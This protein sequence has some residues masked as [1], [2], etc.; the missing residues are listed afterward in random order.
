MK[1]TSL[2]LNARCK[3]AAAFLFAAILS[4]GFTA[5]S[6]NSDNPINPSGPEIT[7]K[8][9]A[10]YAKT[11]TVPGFEEGDNPV[12]FVKMVQ[13]YE[14]EAD[15]TGRWTVF[16]VDKDNV[17]VWQYGSLVGLDYAAGYFNYS[18]NSDGTVNI[19]LLNELEENPHHSWTLHLTG[20]RLTGNDEG[21]TYALAHATA[22]QEAWVKD[23][24]A[25]YHGGLSEAFNINTQRIKW[26][27]QGSIVEPITADNW[28]DHEDI[29]IYIQN[30]GDK[31]I[32][33]ADNG[34]EMHGFEH[35]KLPWATTANESPNL[36]ERIW[37]EVWNDGV[38][39]GNPWS[40]IMMQIG[41]NTV[42][43]GN[44]LAFYNELTG[45]MRF[46]FYVHESITSNG[47]THWWGV[48]M[49]DRLASRSVFRYGAPLNCDIT[50]NAAKDALN[51]PALMGQ[52]ISP[53]VSNNFN[54]S[55]L[56]LQSGWWAFDVDLS[57]YR[58]GLDKEA[59]VATIS[60][61]DNAFT[62]NL[63]AKDNMQVEL[64]SLFEGTMDGNLNLEATYAN[65]ENG[66][67]SE[68]GDFIDK[69]E[70]V[71]G[72][73]MDFGSQ[74]KD[75]YESTMKG[76]PIGQLK[77]IY[78][79]GKKGAT[80]AGLIEEK[81]DEPDKLTG[82]KGTINM[83]MKGKMDTKGYLS[84]NRGVNGFAG[85]VLKRNNFLYDNC[86]TFGEGIWNLEEAPV[87][88][89]TN[90]YYYWT[91][92]WGNV[93]DGKMSYEKGDVAEVR[94]TKTKSPFGGQY[95]KAYYGA[96]RIVNTPSKEPYAGYICYFDP[97]SIKL[98]LNPNVFTAEEIAN[99]K[100]YAV[101]GV[102]SSNS[103]GSTEGY[104][105]AQNLSSSE[106][107]FSSNYAYLN[108]PVDE[109]PF[110]ALSSS[111]DKLG[112]EI[113][114]KFAVNTLNGTQR[115]V[116]GRGDDEYLIEPQALR[117]GTS[118]HMMPAYEVTVTVVVEHNGKPI[119]FS[120]NYLPEYKSINTA[121]VVKF[122][123]DNLLKKK[124]ANY[125]DDVYKQQTN[126]ILDIGKWM[127]R[128]LNPI[129]GTSLYGSI[130][131]L[132]ITWG[133]VFDEPTEGFPYFIDGDINTKWC[134][135]IECRDAG[136]SV[137]APFFSSFEDK[138]VTPG[139]DRYVWALEFKTNFP[140]SPTGFTLTTANDAGVFP[141]RNPVHMAIFVANGGYGNG[142][143]RIDNHNQTLNLPGQNKVTKSYSLTEVGNAKNSQYFRI[144]I[145]HTVDD[146]ESECMQIGEF[147]FTYPE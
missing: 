44:F 54:G 143:K 90:A 48:Q 28:Q 60:D 105:K 30:G 33:N 45:V 141:K 85:M 9:Y 120:R 125:A 100:V 138:A 97:S 89:Y 103:F 63:Y 131:A 124:P 74:I 31:D 24:D 114:K 106:F 146:D 38:K 12:T 68:L 121:D 42:K 95:E 134:S 127:Q 56:P 62:L 20:D 6:D 132:G 40:L 65:S 78:S 51:Q 72:T 2:L 79:L 128:T 107:D 8:W 83:A 26:G 101:C 49:N 53:W 22:E 88:Y 130:N 75:I 15:G 35:H 76:D 77:G 25:K 19:N 139:D 98:K 93:K 94:T 122:T 50:T 110:D 91:Y 108:R 102:R 64:S 126:H 123:S 7:G 96:D 32:Y 61:R 99:A 43:N 142:W 29:F 129:T 109:A 84:A 144:E 37:K 47:S 136:I 23:W 70:S 137:I 92:Y 115:G 118:K 27:P 140:I 59:S 11:G 145:F 57:V 113:G 87:V 112:M 14:F 16:S 1:T 41:E 147:Q 82:M 58:G 73:I 80:M 52:L 10:E 104:R 3:A 69:A 86:A 55:S 71:V 133:H 66:K 34:M 13:Y 4:L 5:C 17:P 117:G 67:S 21:N 18:T 81:S 36:P 39:E 116:F 111:S 119:V 135:S 46:F